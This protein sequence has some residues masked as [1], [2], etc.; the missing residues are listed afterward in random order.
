MTE[1]QFDAQ[2]LH[3]WPKALQVRRILHHQGAEPR[4]RHDVLPSISAVARVGQFGR[5]WA[6]GF[7]VAI[8]HALLVERLSG[9]RNAPFVNPIRCMEQATKDYET[10][11]KERNAS[12]GR[13]GT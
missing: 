8:S 7:D 6:D 3:E 1:D 11:S 4:G 2:Q 12:P 10:N 9:W 13:W 5:V